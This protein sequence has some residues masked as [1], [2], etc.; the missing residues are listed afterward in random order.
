MKLYNFWSQYFPEEIIGACQPTLKERSK[1]AE[2][3]GDIGK[4]EVTLQLGRG[5]P[6]KSAHMGTC[7]VLCN[8]AA[9]LVYMSGVCAWERVCV[10]VCA[11]L[12]V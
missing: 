11:C 10:R 9:V 2:V 6:K 8:G 5:R 3:S 4:N 12:R 7:V 1:L